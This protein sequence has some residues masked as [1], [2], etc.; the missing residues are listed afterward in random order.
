MELEE[1]IA[2]MEELLVTPVEELPSFP[3]G[4]KYDA[5]MLLEIVLRHPVP[6]PP[7]RVR[8]AQDLLERLSARMDRLQAAAVPQ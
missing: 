5:T 4:V 1:L 3:R 2:R 7:D 8:Y 6:V